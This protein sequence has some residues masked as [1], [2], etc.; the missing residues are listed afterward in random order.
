[1]RSARYA[2]KQTSIACRHRLHIFLARALKQTVRGRNNA[3][4]ICFVASP[5]A[6]AQQAREALVTRYGQCCA[7]D[8]DCIVALGGDG[9]ILRALQIAQ[10]LRGQIGAVEGHVDSL[11]RSAGLPPLQNCRL[12]GER[13]DHRT[14]V[15]PGESGSLGRMVGLLPPASSGIC[16][17]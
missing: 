1:M 7:Q 3:M 4:R 13:A 6:L 11:E 8:A 17:Y 5:K 10:E 12:Y 9:T 14:H 2:R 16:A 15:H